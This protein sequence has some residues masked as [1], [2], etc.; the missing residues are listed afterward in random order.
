MAGLT[1]EQIVR[2]TGNIETAGEFLDQ[3][4][5][6]VDQHGRDQKLVISIPF[7]DDIG[8]HYEYAKNISS[9]EGLIDIHTTKP[10]NDDV[11]KTH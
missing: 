1:P 3:L 10:E 8:L 6:M 11:S 5:N 4:Q 2:K 9:H 7:R